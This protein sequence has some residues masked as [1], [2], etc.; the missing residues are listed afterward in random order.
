MKKN[1]VKLNEA[2]L[3]K[4]VAE[5][6]KKA[7]K[8]STN[9]GVLYHFTTMDG[10][11]GMAKSGRVKSSGGQKELSNGKNYISFTRHKTFR[12]GFANAEGMDYPV[13]I[14]FDMAKV[15]SMHGVKTE[16][17]EYYSPNRSKIAYKTDNVD[18]DGL[19][20]DVGGYNA[21]VGNESGKEI[22]RREYKGYHDDEYAAYDEPEYEYYNQAEERLITGN[23]FISTKAITRVDIAY[24]DPYVEQFCDDDDDDYYDEEEP[25]NEIIDSKFEIRG[26]DN[27]YLGN[28]IEGAEKLARLKN[29]QIPL[30]RIFVYSNEADFIRQTNNCL[31][32]MQFAQ[33]IKQRYKNV[34]ESVTIKEAELMNL[35]CESVASVIAEEGIHIKEKNKGKFNATTERTGKSTE[36]LT[37]SKNPLTRKRAIFA[38]NAKKWNKGK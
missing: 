38:Q 25:I 12:E 34:V 11:Y 16:P 35:I 36:E 4:V 29:S 9:I 26:S 5:S 14:E 17:F 19:Y 1:T 10:L 15:N 27:F 37:H 20:S 21:R 28:I 6:V 7:L 33:K 3:R 22:Y 30:D 8:E 2:Q 32:L 13:R 18:E 24:F 23:K 31:T